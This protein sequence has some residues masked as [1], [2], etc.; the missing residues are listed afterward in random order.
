MTTC[1][2]CRQFFPVSFQ[3][4]FEYSFEPH[5][6]DLEEWNIIDGKPFFS[7]IARAHFVCSDLAVFSDLTDDGGNVPQGRET[8]GILVSGPIGRAALNHIDVLE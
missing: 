6:D 7:T 4:P 5:R 2:G 1:L 8:C 3:N